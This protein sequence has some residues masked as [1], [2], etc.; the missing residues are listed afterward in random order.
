VSLYRRL[1]GTQHEADDRVLGDGVVDARRSGPLPVGQPA[2]FQI[3]FIVQEGLVTEMKFF[4][5][6]EAAPVRRP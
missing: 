6:H 3:A 5:D 4:E 1:R 2:S